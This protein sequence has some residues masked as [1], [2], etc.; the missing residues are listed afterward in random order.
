MRGGSFNPTIV[1]NIKDVDNCHLPCPSSPHLPYPSSPPM[2]DVE[3]AIA[4]LTT[5]KTAPK[6]A[7]SSLINELAALGDSG[8]AAVM[9]FL[10]ESK[11]QPL[12]KVQPNLAIGKAY[13][14]LF[15]A[16]TPASVEFLQTHFA[17]GVVPL[18]SERAIAYQ[19]LQQLLAKQE[20]QAADVL[21]LQLLCELA[22]E[23][24]VQRKWVYFTEVEQFAMADL[25]TINALWLMHSDGQFGF[26][27]QRDLWLGVGKN[28][29][30]LWAKIGW[31][32]GN[33]WTRYPQGFTWDLSAPRGHL[34]LS[35][36]LRGVRM[37]ASL[38]NH[39]A[40]E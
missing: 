24:A 23:A 38:F 29:E 10:L 20:F 11:D 27:V 12:G 8:L 28:W 22:G 3:K 9:E 13:Q 32:D 2:S 36:Q 25:Q 1:S 37:I 14:T 19:P 17:E 21:T 18:Q 26:S 30:K 7:Q 40:W 31:K 33:N 4:L 15:L 35:N 16:V 5:L 39:P 6:K 34:P